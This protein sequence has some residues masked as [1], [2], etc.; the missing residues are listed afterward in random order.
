MKPVDSHCHLDFERFDEDRNE[1]IERA[2]NVLNYAVVAGCDPDRNS[3]VRDLCRDD[4]LLVTNY[5]LHPTF[6]ESFDCLE[7]A[8][9]QIREWEPAAVGEIGLDHHQVTGKEERK[10][11]ESIFRSLL[12]LAEELELPVTVHSRDAERRC[13]EVVEKFDIRAF[14]HC[15]NGKPDLAEEI[16]SSGHL[17]GVTTQVLYSDR[18]RTIARSV[19]LESVLIETDSPFL[20]P[21][22]RN[23]PSNVAEAAEELAEIK[24]AQETKVVETTSR[25]AKKFFGLP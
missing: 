22:R 6:T 10:E 3:K 24:S 4:D 9:R 21:D 1:V 2:R 18:V 20:Y 7:R 8:V 11:Q 25:N 12:E 5:G 13:F 17:I 15:F 23:E 19:D 14:F 16:A